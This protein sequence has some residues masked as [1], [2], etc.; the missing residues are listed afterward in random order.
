MKRMYSSN[1][2]KIFIIS[3]VV[4]GI[5]FGLLYFNIQDASNK[6]IIVSS[7]Q[8]IN[9]LVKT[10]HQNMIARH[11]ITIII[12]IFLA[13]S[14]IG[15]PL[16]LFYLFFETTA[17]GFIIASSYATYKISGVIFSLIY[18]LICKIPY[19]L[20]L[21]YISY[22]A[23]KITKKMLRILI[24]KENESIYLMLKNLFLK[25]A[26]TSIGILIYDVLMYFFANKILNLFLFLLK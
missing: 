24:Y 14:I 4:C 15:V 1:V 22:I 3:L 20:C 9:E 19:I 2:A 7:F 17:I 5:L 10:T 16:I 21:L 12:L 25:I 23:L 8:N 26:I 18:I 13:Y 11:L 6:D